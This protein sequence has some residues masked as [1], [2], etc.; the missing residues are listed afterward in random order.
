MISIALK[1]KELRSDVGKCDPARTNRRPG[2]PKSRDIRLPGSVMPRETD[3]DNTDM[4]PTTTRTTAP[5]ETVVDLPAGCSGYGWRDFF[6]RPIAFGYA[7]VTCGRAWLAT[8]ILALLVMLIVLPVLSAGVNKA[9]PPSKQGK[10]FGLVKKEK[11]NSTARVINLVL[12]LTVCIGTGRLMRR[13]FCL[14]LPDRLTA[15]ERL[16]RNWEQQ[17]D[18]LLVTDWTRSRRMYRWAALLTFDPD[19]HER[20]QRRVQSLTAT[21]NSSTATMETPVAILNTSTHTTASIVANSI[22]LNERY[23]LEHKLGEGAMG[24]VY[25][26]KDR[27]LERTVA[28]KQLSGRLLGNEQYTARFTLEARALARLSHPNIVQVYDF[29]AVDDAV[30]MVLEYVDGGTLADLLK[31]R[32]RLEPTSA[33]EIVAAVAEGLA[34]AHDSGIIHRDIKPAN[35]LMTNDSKPKLTDFG[36]AKLAAAATLT[37]AGATLGSP[38]YMSPEQCCGE[39]LDARSDIYSLGITL[40]ELL[41]GRPPFAGD[42]T[43]ILAQHMVATPAPMATYAP[44]IPEGLERLVSKMLVKKREDRIQS[45]LEVREALV[46]FLAGIESNRSRTAAHHAAVGH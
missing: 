8:A 26:G 17:A 13:Q 33:A 21:R 39:A 12:M 42:T 30:W 41:T 31:N 14:Q 25:R 34:I 35:V 45:M 5:D 4:V 19:R 11:P 40:Y 44:G 18:A 1:I 27:V 10:L 29:V 37:Q 46:G 6:Y 16:S 7:V 24:V 3:A 43:G 32:G 9:F 22:G 2:R 38:A 28:I 23:S 20:L 36:I 15:G